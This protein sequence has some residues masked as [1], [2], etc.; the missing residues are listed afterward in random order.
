MAKSCPNEIG[1]MAEKQKKSKKKVQM[2]M[3]VPSLD[4]MAPEIEQRDKPQPLMRSQAFDLSDVKNADVPYIGRKRSSVT[5]ITK[6]NATFHKQFKDLPET[7][8]VIDSFRCALHKE[9]PYHGKMYISENYICFYSNILK[10]T[11]LV[12]PVTE[13][14]VLK[15]QNIALL[16][17]NALCIKTSVGEKHLFASL[18]SRDLTFKCLETVCSHLQNGSPLNSPQNSTESSFEAECKLLLERS[19]SNIEEKS[20]DLDTVDGTQDLPQ[21]ISSTASADVTRIETPYNENKGQKGRPIE[22]I[23]H[24]NSNSWFGKVTKKVK[25]FTTFHESTTFNTLI[26]IYVLLVLLLLVSSGYIGLRIVAIEEQL[27]S[28]GAWPEFD[29]RSQYKRP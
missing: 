3:T 4:S 22:E 26:I 2:L 21:S 18:R 5:S 1:M 16:V 25:S 19:Q 17:P 9:V 28:M 10:E 7:E 8:N 15:K 23:L 13:V 29:T 14:V 27:M 20:Q 11:K 24:G 6:S 12:V